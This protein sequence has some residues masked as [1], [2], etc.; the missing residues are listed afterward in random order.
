MHSIAEILESKFT[1]FRM[2]FFVF[3]AGLNPFSICLKV[4]TVESD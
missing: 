3:V 2:I 1:Y 4:R